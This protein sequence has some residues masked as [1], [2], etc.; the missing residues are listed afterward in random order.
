MV[1]C[2]GARYAGGHY[3]GGLCAGGRYTCPAGEAPLRRATPCQ[4]GKAPLL[5]LPLPLAL[6]LALALTLPLLLSVPRHTNQLRDLEDGKLALTQAEARRLEL[7]LSAQAATEA[8]LR[9]RLAEAEAARDDVA[10]A[11]A[12]GKAALDAQ[13]L[14]LD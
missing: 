9:Q 14:Q 2:A 8:G 13:A 10:N 7:Q 5:E 3:A 1:S 6:A 12:Q 11:K 4:R